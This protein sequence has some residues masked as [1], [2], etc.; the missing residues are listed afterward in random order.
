MLSGEL[1]IVTLEY[2][3]ALILVLIICILATAQV[4]QAL[5]WSV[6]IVDSS[7][8][9]GGG[10]SIAVDYSGNP[11]IS[12][13]DNT[14]GYL[15]YAVKTGN[16]WNISTVDSSGDVGWNTAI[17]VDYSGNPHIS[18]Y[19]NTNGYLKYI[20]V[21]A[22]SLVT[23]TTTVATNTTKNITTTIPTQTTTHTDTTTNEIELNLLSE[24][25]YILLGIGTI[26]IIVAII[27]LTKRTN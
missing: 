4:A 7:G 13:Y 3:R 19:D 17:A 2:K 26:S 25:A 23:T 12:Y 21:L 24:L 11:H 6:S 10:T 9:L 16:T 22:S 1:E 15:K 27:L 18:Y 8:D 14:N 20:F 5:N